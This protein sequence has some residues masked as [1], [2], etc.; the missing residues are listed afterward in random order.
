MTVFRFLSLTTCN[1]TWNVFEIRLLIHK[2]WTKNVLPVLHCEAL[3]SSSPEY[4]LVV[5]VRPDST[6]PTESKIELTRLSALTIFKLILDPNIFTA[7]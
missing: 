2:L 6:L 7:M 4:W 5:D 1:R 3:I